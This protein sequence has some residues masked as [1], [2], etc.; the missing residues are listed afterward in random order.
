[1]ESGHAL[2]R[3]FRTTLIITSAL[4]AGLFLYALVVE[5]VRSQ[6][7]PFSGFLSGI[8]LQT[9]R[10]VFYGAAIGIVVLVRFATKTMAKAAPGE[11]VV[12]FSQRLSR[13]A[14]VT[15]ALA[16]LPA[17]FGFMLFLLVGSWRDFYYL[18]F[19]SLFLEF[20]YFPRLKV[21]QDLIQENFPQEGI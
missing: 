21:W 15:A 16:E 11:D 13:K 5:F 2:R 7:R 1:M 12:L 10:Y 18:L 8:H 19:V 17:V 4:I 20:M 9:L 6:V 3:I 14:I